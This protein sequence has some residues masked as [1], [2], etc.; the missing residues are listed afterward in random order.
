MAA[1]TRGEILTCDIAR[2]SPADVAG[3]KFRTCFPS[4]SCRAYN[5]RRFGLPVIITL[6]LISEL[7][8]RSCSVTPSGRRGSQRENRLSETH[9]EAR[10]PKNKGDRS[11]LGR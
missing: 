3:P 4:A 1:A 7:P 9:S 10:D 6:D 2:L 8:I 5:A 11:P